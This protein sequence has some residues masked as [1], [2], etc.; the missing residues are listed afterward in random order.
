[1][2]T[3]QG[4]TILRI[5]DF[6]RFIALGEFFYKKEQFLQ[7][8]MEEQR[9]YCA[10]GNKEEALMFVDNES[11]YYL[12]RILCQWLANPDQEITVSTLEKDVLR[13]PGKNGEKVLFQLNRLVPYIDEVRTQNR[14]TRKSILGLT[15]LYL[16]LGAN[17]QDSDVPV[18]Y[19]LQTIGS[20]LKDFNEC[21]DDVE[22][23]KGDGLMYPLHRRLF[24]NANP[25]RSVT[26]KWGTKNTVLLPNE[27]LIGLFSG[28]TCHVLLPEKI[29]SS[30]DKV[31]LRLTADVKTQRTRMEVHTPSD[32]VVYHDDVVSMALADGLPVWATSDGVI[33]YP[34]CC[35]AFRM[36]VKAF[37][38]MKYA[39]DFLAF[40]Q[41]GDDNYV[42]Y[43]TN[44]VNH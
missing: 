1:M 39:N 17:E 16:L 24:V 31:S 14:L 22:L 20:Q 21:W 36:R 10:F 42:F 25:Q 34:D 29:T 37:L 5:S 12:L 7:M 30:Q 44:N 33:H 11:E 6:R 13:V 43:T 2:I 3:M 19:E 32:G 4:V 23:E 18:V 9:R 35:F 28:N 26:V 15:V 27:C 41:E 40:V 8:F 38:K